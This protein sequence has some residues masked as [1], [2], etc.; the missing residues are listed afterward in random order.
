MTNDQFE[1]MV[2]AGIDAIPAEFSAKLANVAV[3][4]E[5][6]P[7]AEQ[8]RKLELRP[9]WTLFGLYEGVPLAR[10]GAGYTMVLPDKITIFRRPIEAA[11]ASAADV[12]EIV[13]NTVWHEIAHHFGMNE[14]EVRAAEAKRRQRGNSGV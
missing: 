14:A 11:A 2:A 5:D 12:K 1:A 4:V 13:K 7:T 6:E 8:R 3:V 10:R 9:G